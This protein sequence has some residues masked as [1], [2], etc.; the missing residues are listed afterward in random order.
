VNLKTL[1]PPLLLLEMV[2]DLVLLLVAVLAL[3]LLL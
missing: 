2:T 3:E 1:G